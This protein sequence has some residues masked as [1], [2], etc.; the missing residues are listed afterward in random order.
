MLSL[1]LSFVVFLLPQF[2]VVGE[3]ENHFVAHGQSGE[4]MG[5]GWAI[6]IVMQS[7]N[8]GAHTKMVQKYEYYTRREG[9]RLPPP[10]LAAS[11]K[12]QQIVRKCE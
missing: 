9:D 10:P 4:G 11:N 1:F 5:G 3:R 6:F 8:F 2:S 12:V 7:N